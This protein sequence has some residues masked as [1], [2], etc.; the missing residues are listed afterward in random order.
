[1]LDVQRLAQF[2]VELPFLYQQA[3]GAGSKCVRQ[4]AHEAL[5]Q[6]PGIGYFRS[7]A[8]NAEQ[9]LAFFFAHAVIS[10]L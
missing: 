5:G 9:R 1:M 7:G 3:S 10:A 6:L 4:Q 2:P 8:I